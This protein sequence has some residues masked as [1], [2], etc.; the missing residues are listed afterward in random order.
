MIVL[1]YLPLIFDEI[2]VEKTFTLGDTFLYEFKYNTRN[3]FFSLLIKDE[4]D[5]ILYSTKLIYGGS[6]YHAVV[7]NL[8]LN[9]LIVPFNVADLLTSNTI[10]DQSVNAENLNTRVRLY[11]L[12]E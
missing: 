4:E 1:N 11:L 6:A 12:D 7:D 5:N 9:K 10:D 2:P 3:D 8:G